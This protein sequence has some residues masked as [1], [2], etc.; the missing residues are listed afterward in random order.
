M[1]NSGMK[2]INDECNVVF[3]SRFP[4]SL[5]F[6]DTFFDLFQAMVAKQTGNEVTP[7]LWDP[8]AK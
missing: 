5:T 6:N 1:S 8:N 3:H 4:A 7:L 2:R